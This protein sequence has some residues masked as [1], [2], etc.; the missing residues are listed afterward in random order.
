MSHLTVYDGHHTI[1][2]ECD[3][4]PIGRQA[5]VTGK[6][7][8]KVLSLEEMG[9]IFEV[10]R[11]L[12]NP[13]SQVVPCNFGPLI[14]NW[15]EISAVRTRKRV[16]NASSKSTE[17]RNSILQKPRLIELATYPG[18]TQH[19]A[20]PLPFNLSVTDIITDVINAQAYLQKKPGF[21]EYS[22]NKMMDEKI[23]TIVLD[24]FW[25]VFLDSYNPNKI[26]QEYLFIRTANSFGDF[27]ALLDSRN[28]FKDKFLHIQLEILCQT[29][30]TTYIRAYPTSSNQFDDNFK[31]KICNLIHYWF[32][33]LP[34][35]PNSWKNWPIDK[36]I[37]GVILHH[38]SNDVKTPAEDKISLKL[39]K[40]QE[41]EYDKSK[42]KK[43]VF[44]KKPESNPIHGPSY[45][46]ERTLLRTTGHSPLM[47]YYL[48]CRDIVHNPTNSILLQHSHAH[49]PPNTTNVT[50]YDF[51]KRYN[52]RSQ[53]RRDRMYD[54]MRSTNQNI[55]K[56]RIEQDKFSRQQSVPDRHNLE[57]RDE[58]KYLKQR[59]ILNDSSVSQK[60]EDQ[61]LT[62][63][64]NTIE[65]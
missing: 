32:T 18:Y 60:E 55:M 8:P 40:P 58:E 11:I 48:S 49:I 30:F 15:E 6:P 16:P 31:S 24:L 42:L 36:L 51:L 35:F 50:Y 64:Q 14:D 41:Q 37:Q 46:L 54:I 47:E 59:L 62:Q 4:S 3:K 56:R 23:H 20:T 53:A 13:C 63:L 19:E 2:V 28:K 17:A 10:N 12:S 52:K 21:K 34:P 45:L 22:R 61:L 29:I 33:G 25:W 44:T 27:F 9:S 1:V 26:I 5:I 65:P 57:S 7:P 43:F 38:N 39:S